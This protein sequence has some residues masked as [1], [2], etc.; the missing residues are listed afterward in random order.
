[1]TTRVVMRP[2]A[3][4]ELLRGPSGPVYRM[5][6]ENGELVKREAQRLCPVGT[7]P[8][9][10]SRARAPGTLRDSIV[11]RIREDSQGPVVEVGSSD[12]VALWVH[13]GTQPHIINGNPLLVFFWAKAGRVVALPRVNHP[14]T[15]PNRFLLQALEILRGRF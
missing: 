7:V 5:Q 11:K 6:L 10:G 8:P 2:A 14:G 4:A 12:P 15:Q 13:E 1:M 3:L 9:G